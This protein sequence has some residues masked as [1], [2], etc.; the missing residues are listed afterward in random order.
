M[1][2]SNKNSKF[3]TVVVLNDGET[4]TD[5]SG[6]SICVVPLEKYEEAIRSGGDA[7]HFE[8]VVEIGLDNMTIPVPQDDDGEEDCNIRFSRADADSVSERPLTDAE[9]NEVKRQYNNNR[10]ADS[11]W[12]NL[13]TT[14]HNVILDSFEDDNED[15]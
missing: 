7:R 11:D 12:E 2:M 13:T 1:N 4:F 9:W 6:C 5:I 10:P 15:N 3:V 8:P 14:V